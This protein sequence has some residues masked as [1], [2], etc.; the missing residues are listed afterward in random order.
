VKS[1]THQSEEA[2]RE[3]AKRRAIDK[4]RPAESPA[5]TSE[6]FDPACGSGPIL[7]DAAS[8]FGKGEPSK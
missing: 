5:P 1:R 8:H 7:I 2:A 3:Q 4:K 6:W